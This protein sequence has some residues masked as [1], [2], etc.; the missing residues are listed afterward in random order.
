MKQSKSFLTRSL[1]LALALV[2]LLTSANL[3]TALR[4]F[5][6][7]SDKTV[8]VGQLVAD[9]YEL[10]D[11]EKTLLTSGNLIGE[12][13]EYNV[14]ADE[15]NLVEVDTGAKKITVKDFE[16]W[17][18]VS[19]AIVVGDEVKETV[20]LKDGE[21]TYAFP[22]NAFSVKVTYALTHEVDT[23][24]QEKLLN[25]ASTLKTALAEMLA[26][27]DGTD[28]NLGT[29]VLAM[30]TLVDLANGI[31]VD[32]GVLQKELQFGEAAIAA[33]NALDAQLGADDDKLDLQDMNAQYD[34]AASKTMFLAQNGQKYLETIKA[35]YANLNAIYT[36]ELLTNE[37]VDVYVEAQ[38][39][40]TY[41]HWK[42]FKNN[43]K[44]L[45]V[46]MEGIKGN[47]DTSA[48]A[49]G[50]D[51]A[52]LDAQLA[53]I[54]TI[55]ENTVKNPLDVATASVQKNLSMFNVTVSVKLDMVKDNEVVTAETM[56]PVVVTLGKGATKADILAAVEKSGAEAAAKAEWAELYSAEY[57]DTVVSEL[58]EAL[59]EDV[60]YTI[61]YTPKYFTV[62][63]GEGFEGKDAEELP[64]GYVVELPV[65]EDGNKA[66]D[67]FI[68][69]L[70]LEQGDTYMV[71]GNITITRKLGKSYTTYNLYDLLAATNYGPQGDLVAQILKSG[72]LNGNKYF[73]VRLPEATE[74]DDLLNLFEGKLE[75]AAYE[76]DYN[77]LK[78]APYTYQ[79][80]NNAEVKFSG[81]SV[82]GLINKLIKVKYA[83]DLG[84]SV[85]Q[86]ED[87]LAPIVALPGEAQAQIA[88]LERLMGQY[89]AMATLDKI[90]L[91]ALNGVIDVTDLHDDPA[92][93]EALKAEFKEI[94]S[95]IIKNNLDGSVLKIY[96][97]LTAYDDEATGGL[98][99]YYANAEYVKNEIAA[100]SVYLNRMT[101]TPEKVKALEILCVAADYPE[102]KDK[103][104][105]LG[106][107]MAEVDR[108]LT[109]PSKLI[110]LKSENLYDLVEILQNA[111]TEGAFTA[112]V[113]VIVSPTLSA[114]DASLVSVQVV[115]T[116]CGKTE[117]FA[118]GPFDRGTVLSQNIVEEL[119]DAAQLFAWDQFAPQHNAFYKNN[120]SD[121]DALSGVQLTERVKTVYVNFTPV[122]FNIVING[123]V[124]KVNINN[125]SIT[126]PANGKDGYT[127]EFDVFGKKVTTS[128]KNVTIS[129]T[130]DN[131]AAIENG[132]YTVACKEIY[133]AQEDL[134]DK[135]NPTTKPTEPADPDAPVDPE[136][137][138]EAPEEPE[139][140][141]V[142]P[143]E[144]VINENG[145][146]TGIVAN[147]EPS[148]GGVMAFV[149]KLT[150]LGYS[151]IELNGEALVEVDEKTLVSIEALLN[152]MLNDENFGSETL[153][154]LAKNNGGVL[155]TAK[156]NLGNT[157]NDARAVKYDFTD[158]DFT[159]KFTT[160]PAQMVTVG[161]GLNAIKNYM[162]FK[163]NDGVLDINLNLPD[164]VYELYLTAMMSCGELDSDALYV[165]NEIAYQF[166]RDYLDIILNSD[167]TAQSFQNS[168][169]MLDDATGKMPDVDL[170]AYSAYYNVLKNALTNGGIDIQP[171]GEKPLTIDVNA[172]GMKAINGLMG[173][174]GIDPASM[175]IELAMVKEYQEGAEPMSVSM[176]ATL[177]N[178][179]QQFEAA[180]VDVHTLAEGA[181]NKDVK[182]MSHGLDF[183]TDLNARM[184]DVKSASAIVLLG[185]VK[186]D[187]VLNHGTILDLNGHFINGNLVAN[188][189]VI[190][191]D[192]TL[193]TTECG[194]VKGKVSGNAHI[195]AGNYSHDVS[196]FLRDGYYQDEKG[197]VVNCMFI[198]EKDGDNLTY[199]LNSDYMYSDDLSGYLPSVRAVAADI[200][201]DIVSHKYLRAGLT[202]DGA[203]LYKVDFDNLIALLD[204]DDKVHDL[205]DKVLGC[206]NKDGI[207][208]YANAIIDDLLNW[209]EMEKALANDEVIG[210]HLI[211][212]YPWT[213]DVQ[214]VKE[215]DHVDFGIVANDEGAETI[216]LGIK[217]IGTN[218]D[219]L[220]ALIHE[221]YDI[222]SVDVD[223]D[224]YK[225]VWDRT[226][227][228]I[229]LG[230]DA[231]THIHVDLGKSDRYSKLDY[232]KVLTVIMANGNPGANADA[233]IAG[234]N[235]NDIE[236][237]KNAFDQMTVKDV[238]DAMKK[239]NKTDDFKKLAANVGVE[240]D[241]NSA[242]KL[243]NVYHLFI[244]A[245][246]KILEKM[247]TAA[248]FNLDN[249]R[250]ENAEAKLLAKL[251]SEGLNVDRLSKVELETLENLKEKALKKLE[252]EVLNKQLGNLDT[253][254]DGVY[255]L[256]G[257]LNRD[258]DATVRGYTGRLDVSI[259][260][261]F[262][263]DIFGCLWGD[264]D[265]DWDVDTIDAMMVMQYR[266]GLLADDVVFC[267][268]RTDVDQKNG[269]NTIDA[270]LI[271]QYRAGLINELPV[272]D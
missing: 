120:L 195:I 190:I 39:E 69:D 268:K 178:T 203:E 106:A 123:N 229:S 6:A 161:N 76:S 80:G 66:Y 142:N 126:L 53:A 227:N 47:W 96:N 247:Q 9:N 176:T 22:E 177:K 236:A 259:E 89:S 29:I 189:N 162:N 118:A 85:A 260:V 197:A 97:I 103:I 20:A 210:D 245:G 249:D 90:K 68:G 27:F 158:L 115:V 34:A 270:M 59:T 271:M 37:L 239:L 134:L 171:N 147:I 21:G 101:E 87:V 254:D 3:G 88:A 207:K 40:A 84:Y 191:L 13:I 86:I 224:L 257:D 24:V 226:E 109:M 4:V 125:R 93:N 198:A 83:L 35:T 212:T 255:V 262:C 152:A 248:M 48:L 127:F 28:A 219:A 79:D 25:A 146:L 116:A 45:I 168:L 58:P 181:S 121:I 10:T 119:K 137:P 246:G 265:H 62:V 211:T 92:K 179:E 205:V 175:S 71:D 199:V 250:L 167:A 32:L 159:F 50:C 231:Y 107:I 222:V 17:T 105:D 217:I 182:G 214:Y 19:A 235:A 136:A 220:L 130:I 240:L 150:G 51:Y 135:L 238:F 242:D 82:S 261:K 233:M 264:A 72:A 230:G 61:T 209:R 201:L 112:K 8:T 218:K 113:P 42:V 157:N 133:K 139:A 44:N 98:H 15:D 225:P 272:T 251:K 267:T 33:V 74:A 160:V 187:L 124:T 30:P 111:E 100:L 208:A 129:L 256:T 269:I 196:G 41:T 26:V 49:E 117:T 102:Y 57:Y 12:T 154:N 193:A 138:T 132:T 114:V 151:H 213:L 174:V 263:I 216:N 221:L 234:L 46:A 215:T 180:I 192:S 64:Y 31:T 1:S 163:A 73:K 67:Y 122:N 99:Y 128:D 206:F 145:Q 65:H 188:G 56:A 11:A 165:N 183:V 252:T 258:V 52:E 244:A 232:I 60:A 223:L 156:M 110:N 204:S 70:K 164:K 77:G 75:A 202:V 16:D 81:N 55:S 170:V 241:V 131:L 243:E 228:Y 184:A 200:A 141:A 36:D 144:P 169:D 166:L 7:E 23:A 153:I 108:D 155:F 172:S 5:A 237:M 149:N 185:D 253:D 186:G 104:A 43:L 54:T 38:D 14:P 140:P 194:G 78:W 148:M 94:V 2:L 173:L 91:G 143:M 18:P 95:G 63:Y 266:A